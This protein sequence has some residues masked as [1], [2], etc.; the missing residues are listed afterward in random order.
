MLVERDLNLGKHAAHVYLLRL[1]AVSPTYV[2]RWTSVLLST[3]PEA[4]A[5]VPET[6]VPPTLWYTLTTPRTSIKPCLDLVDALAHSP[7]RSSGAFLDV[8]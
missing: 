8:R 5:Y 6:Q 1:T 7:R 2:D 4:P 3:T